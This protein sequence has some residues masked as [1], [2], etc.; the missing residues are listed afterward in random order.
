MSAVIIQHA[1]DL[2]D[3][4]FVKMMELTKE[5]HA[6]YCEAHGFDFWHTYEQ[7]LY[8]MEDGAWTKIEL[9]QRAMNQ[10]YQDIIWIDADALIVDEKVDLRKAV[11]VGKIG[12]CWH[13]IPQLHHWNVGVLYISNTEET[14]KFVDEWL[15]TYPPADGWREQGHFNRMALEN[16]VVVTLSDRWNATIDVSMVPDAVVMGFHGQNPWDRRYKQML[17]AFTQ[18]YPEKV[19]NAGA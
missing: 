1:Y 6:E 17:D 16:N 9:I 8:S 18:L 5:H 11:E 12:A 4:Y 10:G 14:H 7:G 15:A 13:R 2:P 3:S 19:K